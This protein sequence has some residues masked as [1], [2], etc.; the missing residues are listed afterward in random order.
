[1]FLHNRFIVQRDQERRQF[2]SP[3]EKESRARSL[4]GSRARTLALLSVISLA[5]SYSG[6]AYAV[7]ASSQAS[8][9]LSLSF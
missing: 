8:S 9:D 2:P 7:T 4:M 1:M 5:A 3:T 6:A